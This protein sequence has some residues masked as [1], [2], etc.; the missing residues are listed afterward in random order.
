MASLMIFEV[1]LNFMRKKMRLLNVKIHVN[2]NNNKL[3]N[4]REEKIKSCSLAVS[5]IFLRGIEEFMFLIMHIN[6]AFNQNC[7]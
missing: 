4:E 1:I 2:F 5:G 7:Y 6:Y 3:I